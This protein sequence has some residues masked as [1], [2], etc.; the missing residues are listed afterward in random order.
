MPGVFAQGNLMQMASTAIDGVPI[1]AVIKLVKL[2]YCYEQWDV[3][4]SLSE[5]ARNYV[6]VSILSEPAR[7]YVKV[8]I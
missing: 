7:N 2:A 5:P 3:F 4:D 1:S 6:K 8:S